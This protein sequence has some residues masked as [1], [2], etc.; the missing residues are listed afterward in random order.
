MPGALSRIMPATLDRPRPL[1]SGNLGELRPNPL[2]HLPACN[3]LAWNSR[4]VR[5]R[6]VPNGSLALCLRAPASTAAAACPTQWQGS[7][8]NAHQHVH[9]ESNLDSILDSVSVSI[10]RLSQTLAPQRYR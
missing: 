4:A 8:T 6:G 10:A 3:P 9:F 7:G 2:P 1:N 5:L